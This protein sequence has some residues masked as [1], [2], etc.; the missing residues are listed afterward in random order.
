M[1][2]QQPQNLDAL[3]EKARVALAAGQGFYAVEP[4][5]KAMLLA[6]KDWRAATLLAVALDQAQRPAEATAAHRKA[7]ELAPDNAV[8]LSNAA[9]F[10]ASQGD[11][12]QAETLLRKAVSRP[13]AS[14]Q[15][16]QNLALVLGL[17][18]KLAEAE[19]IERQDLPPQMAEAN[20][21]YLRAAAAR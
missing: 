9:M 19:Q 5:R 21:D 11:N 18:G 4:T 14:L 10:Y 8:V 17:E 16:R 20:L 3:L 13:D 12:T 7:L 2:V 1:L 6:P 15:V